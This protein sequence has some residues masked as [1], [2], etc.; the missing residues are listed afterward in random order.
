MIDFFVVLRPVVDDFHDL[1]FA[2]HKKFVFILKFRNV[3]LQLADFFGFDKKF[4]RDAQNQADR[5][6]CRD[7]KN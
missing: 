2:F 7:V 3:V 6:S 4:N 5:Q 1:R